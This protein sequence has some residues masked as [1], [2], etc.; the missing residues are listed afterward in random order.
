MGSTFYVTTPIY[1]VN[2]EPH[3]GTAYTTVAADVLARYH[4]SKGEQVF[5]L[6]GTDEHGQHVA[7]AAERNAVE[8]RE[9][10]DRM[11]VKFIDVWKRLNISN[12]HFIRTTSEEH[13]RVSQDFV[14]KL[15][16]RGDIYLGMY[17]GWYCVPDESFWLPSQL[18]D[19]K[20]P[21]CGRD[22]ELI[23]EENYFFKL[24]KYQDRLLEHINAHPDFILPEIRRNEVMSFIQQGLADQSISRKTLTWGIPL[25]FDPGQVLY[26]WFDALLNYISASGYGLQPELFARLWPANWHLIG[27][28]ILRFHAVIWPAM[29]MA[30]GLPLPEHV[31]AHGWLTVEGEKMS[32]SKGNAISPHVLLDEVS[33]D[34]Y[35]YY[36]MREFSFGTDG[37]FSRATLRSRYNSE[38]ANDLGNLVSRVLAMVDRYRG[39]LVP[40]APVEPGDDALDALDAAL[41]AAAAD[42]PPEVDQ[43]FAALEFNNALQAIWNFVGAANRYV[44]QSAP[45]DLNK[46]PALASRLD[47][48]LYNQVE[49]LRIIG[50]L[51]LPFMPET[52][53]KMWDQLGQDSDIYQQHLPAAAAWGQ[54]PAGTK[55][56]RG[57]GLFPRLELEE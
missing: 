54:M 14:Q 16:E 51:I 40:A 57:A 18:V 27:K 22:V 7:N 23:K 12:D 52:A 20:C 45:W 9:W 41:L 34:A 8:P 33:V 26:V 56:R 3:I 10:A 36:F 11:V 6:T 30:A 2:D 32:K 47:A 19:G 49:A 1:Y 17:E 5:F 42:C 50:L 15:Y 55:V 13:G 4:R 37:N 46:D 53:E 28:E 38:L 35:R 39:G 29:L 31:F 21:Q 44:D 43:R 48:V 25:P 24:S